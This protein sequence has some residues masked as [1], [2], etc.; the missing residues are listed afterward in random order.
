[1]FLK[2]CRRTVHLLAIDARVALGYAAFRRNA[3]SKAALA[4]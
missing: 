1:L 4:V 3:K 2:F